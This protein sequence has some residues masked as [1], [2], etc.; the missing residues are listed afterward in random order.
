MQVGI[1]RIS[2]CCLPC[3]VRIVCVVNDI[4]VCFIR[5]G[6]DIVYHIVPV[7]VVFCL[8]SLLTI[9]ASVIE[10]LFL[11]IIISAILYDRTFHHVHDVMV[12]ASHS[13]PIKVGVVVVGVGYCCFDVVGFGDHILILCDSVFRGS[14]LCHC[15]LGCCSGIFGGCLVSDDV[16]CTFLGVFGYVPK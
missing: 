5:T 1:F 9:R 6:V 16:V 7:V 8:D 12:W 15:I 2:R 11:F 3:C 10:P 13:A 14:F 4:C